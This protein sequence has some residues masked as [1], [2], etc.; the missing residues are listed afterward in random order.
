MKEAVKNQPE[1]LSDHRDPAKVLSGFLR[2]VLG[3]LQLAGLGGL[4]NILMNS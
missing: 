4:K 2:S 1:A 3:N